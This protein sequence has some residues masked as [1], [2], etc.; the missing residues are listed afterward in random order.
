MRFRPLHF[1]LA[2]LLILS[3]CRRGAD[4][5]SPSNK[6][7][8]YKTWLNAN[9]L[10]FSKEVLIFTANGITASGRLNWNDSKYFSNGGIE[11][12]IVPFTFD[13]SPF[14]GGLVV[15]TSFSGGSQ[16]LNEIV[17]WKSSMGVIDA[18]WRH[19]ALIPASPTSAMKIIETFYQLDGSI[20]SVRSHE[21]GAPPVYGRPANNGSTSRVASCSSPFSVTTH[22]VNCGGTTMDNT[23]CVFSKITTTY[24]FC[25]ESNGSGGEQPESIVPEDPGY[26]GGYLEFVSA[27]EV[28]VASVLPDT[29]ITNNQL[30][31]CLYEKLMSANLTK[32]ISSILSAFNGTSYHLT[33]KLGSF[34]NSNIS[35][36]TTNTSTNNFVITINRENALDPFFSRIWLAKT[37]IHEAFHAKLRQKAIE[38][39]GTLAISQ[40]PKSIDDM[41]LSEL[42]S[43]FESESLAANTWDNA[44]HAWMVNHITLCAQ[45]LQEFVQVFYPDKFNQLSTNGMNPYIALFYRGLEG[46]N[47]IGADKQARGLTDNDIINFQ[48]ALVVIEC[49]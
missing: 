48:G 7:S 34:P 47:F 1:T 10:V 3:A 8:E 36:S 39:F 17:F 19:R 41:D 28:E 21:A 22:V 30:A 18:R 46:V 16:S 37:F 42:M 24:I 27:T 6:N 13:R 20:Q 35:G 4:L 43:Y 38:C 26:T 2:L 40:W 9:G 23:V 5:Q 25:T 29:S 45:S 15:D 11:L 33:F 12:V 44:N 14:K 32:G 31:N 49:S